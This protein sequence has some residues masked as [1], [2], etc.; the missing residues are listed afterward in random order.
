MKNWLNF[1][2][3]SGAVFSALRH[4]RPGFTQNSEDPW[5][6]HPYG[7]SHKHISLHDFFDIAITNGTRGVAQPQRTMTLLPGSHRTETTKMFIYR[8]FLINMYSKQKL[9]EIIQLF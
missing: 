9:I 4:H 6:R 5:R 3:W 1:K 8:S 2:N 7:V